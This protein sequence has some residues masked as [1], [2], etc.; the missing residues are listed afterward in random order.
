VP[1]RL[2]NLIA[3]VVLT[4]EVEDIRHQVERMAVILDFRVKAS[5]VKSVR[6][7]VFVDFAE[8][9]VT[10][11]GYEL[12]SGLLAKGYNGLGLRYRI[13]LEKKGCP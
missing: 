11:R 4:V 6:Q 12:R 7:V 2:L 8:V 10:A 9:L 3:C 1:C 13:P 5:Q